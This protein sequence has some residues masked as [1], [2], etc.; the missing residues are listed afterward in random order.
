MGSFLCFWVNIFIDLP[1]NFLNFFFGIFG[2]DAPSLFTGVQSF[3]GC[4]V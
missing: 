1:Q 3:F 2:L 4:N